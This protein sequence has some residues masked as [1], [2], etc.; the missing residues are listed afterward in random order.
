M[1]TKPTHR[2]DAK[3]ATAPSVTDLDQQ[4]KIGLLALERTRVPM[5]V[6]DPRQPDNPIVLA[7]ESFLEMTG[8]SGEEIL[9][10]NCRFLQGPDTDLDTIAEIRDAIAERREITTEILNYHRDGQQF[11]NQ[12]L[13]S[14]VF[15]SDGEIR[16]F[17]ASQIDVTEKYAN[18]DLKDAEHSLLKEIDHRAKNALTL[19]QSIMRLTRSED[20][21][22]YARVV[23]GRVDALARAHTLLAERRWRGV[24]ISRLVHGEIEPFGLQRVRVNGPVV[25]II[26]SQV[27]PLALLLHEMLENA[28]RHGALSRGDGQVTLAWSVTDGQDLV[29]NWREISDAAACREVEPAL[30]L[31]MVTTMIERQLRGRSVFQ[32]RPNGLEAEFVFPLARLGNDRDAAAHPDGT[33]APG[34]D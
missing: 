14:P 30:G 17:F 31:T 18:R 27:Q 4:H 16:F 22:A 10:R 23:Q 8:Y 1:E 15:D 7:N 32:W 3:L 29:L 28:A 19:V 12:L 2:S 13:I 9:G 24:S 11:W 33:S 21:V 5:V 20:A 6:T 34:A 26:S 25:N